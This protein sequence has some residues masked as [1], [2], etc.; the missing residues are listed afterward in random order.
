MDMQRT[1]IRKALAGLRKEEPA[2]KSGAG[3]SCGLLGG[4]VTL[5]VWARK[6]SGRR[7]SRLTFP[8]VG[9]AA[10]RRRGLPRQPVVHRGLPDPYALR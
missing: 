1:E 7:C 6:V 4:L 3:V 2:V 5:W 10:F 9:G 8:P